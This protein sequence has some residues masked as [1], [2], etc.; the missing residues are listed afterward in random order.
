MKQSVM[1]R[2]ENGEFCGLREWLT[3]RGSVGVRI[4]NS[5]LEITGAVVAEADEAVVKMRRYAEII[6]H[7]DIP[8]DYTHGGGWDAGIGITYDG[9]YWLS[10]H[11][12]IDAEL[13]EAEKIVKD[14]HVWLD[15]LA[16]T[17]Y[18]VEM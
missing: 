12:T 5:P 16:A 3:N 10:G 7:Y 1:L 14:L 17:Q 15:K 18:E 13:A 8:M 6:R 2:N 9:R 11:N 4:C